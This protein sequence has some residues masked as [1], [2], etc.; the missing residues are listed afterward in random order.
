MKA[1]WHFRTWQDGDDFIN[2]LASEQFDDAGEGWKPGE[3]LVRECIQNSLDAK[4][5]GDGTVEVHFRLSRA[6]ALATDRARFWF[7]NLWPHLQSKECELPEIDDAPSA[8]SFFVVEDFGTKGLEG[9]V[10]QGQPSTAENRFFNFFRAEGLTGNAK[11]AQTGGSWGVGKSVFNRCSSI[12]SFLALS[13]RRGDGMSILFGKSTLR[14]H[15]IDDQCFWYEGKF[16]VQDPARPN[17]VLPLERGE[18]LDHFCR[19]F[20]IRRGAESPGLSIAIP[21]RHGSVNAKDLAEIV[22]REYFFPIVSNELVVK[23]RDEHEG[24][25]EVRIDASTIQ[26]L[27][28]RHL[29]KEFCD[30]VE[31]ACWSIATERIPDLEIGINPKEV[32]EWGVTTVIAPEQTASLVERFESRDRLIVRIHVNVFPLR[33]EPRPASFDLYLQQVPFDQAG[34]KPV[35]VRNWTVVP[36]VR[37]RSL[38]NRKLLSIVRIPSGPLGAMLKAAEPPSHTEW[39]ESTT[40]FESR[41]D[42]K[43]GKAVIQF[44]VQSVKAVVDALAGANQEIDRSSWAAFFPI[45]GEERSKRSVKPRPPSRRKT[46][47]FD[48]QP[49][50]GNGVRVKRHADSKANF[51]F[52]HI[53]AA[54][55][56][57]GGI[58]KH[59]KEDFDLAAMDT[60]GSTHCRIVDGSF[61][62]LRLQVLDSA[63]FQLVVSGFDARRDL[64][65]E[66][67]QEDTGGGR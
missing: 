31:L 18:L 50:G 38:H 28:A 44:V 34:H 10:R 1:S 19:D 67:T 52:V 45:P 5:D 49:S 23:I 30:L 62:M 36:N 57:S 59:A 56:G 65:I 64:V 27:A 2:P 25:G 9:D 35:F 6:N 37:R 26:D 11:D 63:R 55:S 33:S 29:N 47:V 12:N 40:N 21:V 41:F 22:I 58:P 43:K 60:S 66:A 15:K 4:A 14:W 24:G 8:T 51:N 39:S 61:D 17:F 7:G 32:A 53:R 3:S 42:K 48:I 13:V 16:G 46:P 54:Y 20:G